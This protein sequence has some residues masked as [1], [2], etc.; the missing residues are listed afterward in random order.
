MVKY[1]IRKLGDRMKKLDIVMIILVLIIGGVIFAAYFDKMHVDANSAQLGIYY[2]SQLV[3]EPFFLQSDTNLTYH[4]ESS[5]DMQKLYIT[6]IDHKRGTEVIFT[7]NYPQKLLI[8][9]TIEIKD[10]VVKIVEASCENKDC[11]RMYMSEK[12]T[13]P[14]VCINGISVMFKEF[15]VISGSPR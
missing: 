5:S 2:N 13:N 12:Y 3:D 7:K 14:I 10:G 11:M 8:D 15:K 4:I 9:H 1:N 6:K